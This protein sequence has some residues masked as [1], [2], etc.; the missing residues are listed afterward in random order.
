MLVGLAL[1]ASVEPASCSVNVWVTPFAV[2]VS[3]TVC[4]VVTAVT[5]AEKLALEAPAATVTEAG[6]VTALLLLAR[7]MVKPPLAAATFSFTE[8]LSVVTPVSELL[9]QVTF[10]SAG[11]PVPLRLMAV[12]PPVVELLV[13][14]RAPV[15]GPASVGSNCNV[16][17]AV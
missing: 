12:E 10:V 6:T 8:Q 11:M 17:V 4:A 7:P 5:V 14:V 3:I 9:L 15:S 16:R 2:A 13:K 1:N